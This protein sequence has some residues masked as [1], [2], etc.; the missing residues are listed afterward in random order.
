MKTLSIETSCD[1]TSLAIVSYKNW[2]FDVE[3]ILLH[4]QIA[5]HTKFGWVIP[6]L[7]SR[8][9]E[10]KVIDLLDEI[11]IEEVKKVD[12]ISYTCCPGLPWSLLVGKTLANTLSLFLDKKLTPVHHINWH[13]LSILCEEN[14]N[15]IQF[16]FIALTVSWGHNNLYI[17]E[18]IKEKNNINK[19]DSYTGQ[20]QNN[21]NLDQ[22]DIITKIWDL[23]I[24]KIWFTLDDAAWEAFDK[25]SRMLWWPYPGG[26]WIWDKAKQFKNNWKRKK[27]WT[28]S[29]ILNQ[30]WN[31]ISISFP[32]IWLKKKEFNFSFSWLKASVNYKIQEIK[33]EIEDDLNEEI[34]CNIAYEFEQAVV[35]TLWKKLLKA[36]KYF[37]IENIA[38]VG[39]VS[40]NEE[41][42]K[43]ITHH[44]EK[45]WVKN[46]YTPKKNLYSTDN[47]AMIWVAGI[48]ENLKFNKN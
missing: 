7:A 41:L 11:W 22:D 20:L 45:F 17:V 31:P 15:N 35:E 8:L 34:I 37:G 24:T 30:S 10:N 46:F 44:K 3:K 42:K 9:H 18:N 47:A 29:E 43:F 32:R 27:F 16:P 33:K 2:F 40:A 36:A 5:E 14:I 12:F 13:I 6:E 23:K 25:V 21:Y 26:K 48:I 28:N 1:D 4:S 38:L 39:G 19:L